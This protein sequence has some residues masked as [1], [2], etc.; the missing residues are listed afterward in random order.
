MAYLT[1]SYRPFFRGEVAGAP[2]ARRDRPG[3]FSGTRRC[4]SETG[5][6]AGL[7]TPAVGRTRCAAWLCRALGRRRPAG[8]G[9][10]VRASH[11][12]GGRISGAYAPGVGAPTLS[13]SHAH[14]PP[15]A[16]HLRGGA[17][18][19]YGAGSIRAL[20]G[21]PTQ[22]G[23][24]GLP[25]PG[26]AV[27][28]PRSIFCIE[29]PI[30]PVPHPR[31]GTIHAACSTGKPAL[32]RVRI[33]ERRTDASLLEV[34]IE[35]GKPHQIRIHLAAAGHPLVGDPLYRKGGQVK[36]G[37]VALPGDIGYHLHAERLCLRHPATGWP[38]AFWCCPPPELRGEGMGE[39]EGETWRRGDGGEEDH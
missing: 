5:G 16:R 7:A 31:L 21:F 15:G 20:R 35:T 12:P 25:G 29:A 34:T 3:W 1:R 38:S 23:E 4:H 9:K 13:R 39:G 24:Q 11:R 2:G 10:T 32:S 19:P 36:E 6:S 30:G 17:L 26:H 37:D 33:L 27:S 8:R 22:R 28:L 14:A 18:R